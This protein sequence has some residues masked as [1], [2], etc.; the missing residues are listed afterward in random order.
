MEIGDTFTLGLQLGFVK[1]LLN[2]K[3]TKTYNSTKRLVS[4]SL[5]IQFT[6]SNFEMVMKDKSEKIGFILK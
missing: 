5:P 1:N 2:L 3:I 6:F 4:M